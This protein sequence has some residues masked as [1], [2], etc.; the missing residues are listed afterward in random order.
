[1][2]AEHVTMI[3]RPSPLIND[4]CESVVRMCECPYGNWRIRKFCW[5][6]G[7]LKSLV[8]LIILIKKTGFIM[9]N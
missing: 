7:V 4:E 1:M 9:K 5:G 6:G 3:P 8:H 2:S